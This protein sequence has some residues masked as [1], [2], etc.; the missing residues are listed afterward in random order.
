MKPLKRLLSIRRV[1]C[2]LFIFAIIFSVQIGRVNATISFWIAKEK[3]LIPRGQSVV[4]VEDELIYVIGGVD[5][6]N[7]MALASMEIYDLATNSWSTG[8]SLPN[9]TRGAAGTKGLDGIL[10]VISGAGLGQN[11]VQAY[12]PTTNTWTLKTNIPKSVWAADAATGEDGSIYVIGGSGGA[13]LCTNI[14]SYF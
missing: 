5:R 6:T 9:A 8:A 11:S 2:I 14:Q 4:L 7:G 1:T 10:Y 13:D 3:M 12:N